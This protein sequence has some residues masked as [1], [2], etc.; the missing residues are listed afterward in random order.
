MTHHPGSYAGASSEGG[1]G[2]RPG[3]T[4]H[5]VGRHVH[6][7]NCTLTATQRTLCCILEN[8]QTKEGV[9]VNSGR[10][11]PSPY[12]L[13]EA[14]QQ[15]RVAVP[16]QSIKYT[17]ASWAFTDA[18]Q[19]SW[20]YCRAQVPPVLQPFMHGQEFIPF[21]RQLGAQAGRTLVSLLLK[22]HP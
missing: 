19:W 7:L 20:P 5:P 11:S 9:K 15:C 14:S 4:N 22:R 6:M 17:S 21:R 16:V 2:T 1:G 13:K 12:R 10:D 3:P 18:S 8:H